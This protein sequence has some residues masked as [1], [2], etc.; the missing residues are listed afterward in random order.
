MNFEVDRLV[1]VKPQ[2]GPGGELKPLYG[3]RQ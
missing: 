2:A 3:L 1:L